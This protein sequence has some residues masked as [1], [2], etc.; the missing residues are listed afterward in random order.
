MVKDIFH[1]V[2]FGYLTHKLNIGWNG[3]NRIYL[4]VFILIS[5]SL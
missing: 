1:Q 4:P 5:C 3:M 2:H